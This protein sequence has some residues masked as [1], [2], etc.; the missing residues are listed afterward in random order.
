MLPLD[1]IP[2]EGPKKF[3]ITTW[4]RV[5]D[6]SNYQGNL[7]NWAKDNIL[8]VEYNATFVKYN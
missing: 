5:F 2:E 6:T 8:K 7:E 1:G 4:A 3:Y